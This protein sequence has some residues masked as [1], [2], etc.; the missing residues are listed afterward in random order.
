MDITLFNLVINSSNTSVIATVLFMFSATIF[1]TSP[2]SV[3]PGVCQ[4]MGQ[5]SID[6]TFLMPPA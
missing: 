2:S 1:F 6:L 5:G 4:I 3:V